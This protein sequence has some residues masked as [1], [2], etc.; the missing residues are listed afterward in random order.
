MECSASLER[1]IPDGLQRLFM[2]NIMSENKPAV[3]CVCLVDIFI[4]ARVYKE[5]RTME[6]NELF[7]SSLETMIF[8]VN[9]FP[10]L[11]LLPETQKII[12]ENLSPK[13]RHEIN[14]V[15]NMYNVLV[16]EVCITTLVSESSLSDVAD[17]KLMN[18]VIYLG[19]L[20]FPCLDECVRSKFISVLLSLINTSSALTT[21]VLKALGSLCTLDVQHGF[22]DSMVDEILEVV[23]KKMVFEEESSLGAVFTYFMPH[24]SRRCHSLSQYRTFLLRPIDICF[25]DENENSV[26]SPLFVR[27]I[28]I[29]CGLVDTLFPV[30]G[31][32]QIVTNWL[33]ST[34]FWRNLQRGFYHQDFMTRKRTLYLFRRILDVLH[35]DITIEKS[36]IVSSLE[37]ESFDVPVFNTTAIG[38]SQ[39]YGVWQEFMLI[40]ETLEEKQVPYHIY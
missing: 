35:V 21:N 9:D 12:S 36:S 17:R 27:G 1:K 37:S 40:I 10:E 26:T 22:T 8:F 25:T 5:N 6:Q 32:N 2:K 33:N 31:V 24:M 28:L 15:T 18:C 3:F 38:I 30:T 29:C 39:L 11:C 19:V 14:F 20:C 23:H 7:A 16:M 34:A 13:S 4:Q